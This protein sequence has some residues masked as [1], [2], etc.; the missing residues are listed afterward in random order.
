MCIAFTIIA[1][2]LERKNNHPRR[3]SS[4]RQNAWYWFG[5]RYSEIIKQGKKRPS[6]SGM[7]C[8]RLEYSCNRIL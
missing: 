4:K 2:R 6:T 8:A 3:F 7:E 1:F 5:L